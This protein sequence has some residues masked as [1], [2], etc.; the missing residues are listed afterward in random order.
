LLA[1]QAALAVAIALMA[2]HRPGA[3]LQLIAVNAVA[4]AFLSATQD[5]TIDAYRV[6]VLQPHETGAGAAI[7]VLGYRIA[8]I[9]VGAIGLVLADR[10]S[11]PAVYLMAA[12]IMV[13]MLF[14]SLRIPEPAVIPGAPQS[15]INA[16]RMPFL[17]YFGRLGTGRGAWILAFIVLYRLGDSMI[18]NMTTPF[19]LQTG[20]T[21][22]DVGAVQGAVGLIATIAGILAGG[23]VLS[24]IGVYASLWVF[25]VLQAVSNLAYL[26]LAEA[27]RNYI[28]MVA[29]I[30]TENFCFGLGSAA[31]LGFLISLCNPRFSATQYA[32]LSSVL[33]VSRDVIVS[34]A[35]SVAEMPRRPRFYLVSFA[36]AL[37]ALLLLPTIKAAVE[38]RPV[39]GV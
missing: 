14:A 1:T 15:M 27:G 38:N 22:T 33:G 4:I 30:I 17:D 8:L 20:F 25:G 39:G 9:V 26:A 3:A 34:P 7:S 32:L 12:G 24:R 11:W 23:G 28:L 19:L 36:A 6:D 37:P 29:T 16:V 2:F 18:T 35:G 13:V 10:L 31:L 21:L 5:I